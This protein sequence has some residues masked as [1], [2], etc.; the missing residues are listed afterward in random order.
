MS[1]SESCGAAAATCSKLS[2]S[3]SRSLSERGFQE[4][5]QR[6]SSGV[7]ES[8]RLGDGGNDQVGIAD[9]SQR[10]E[11]HP[12]GK[13]SQQVRGDLQ[14]QACFADAAGASEGQ[15]AHLWSAQQT[16]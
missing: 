5:Q 9:G 15:Q 2:S 14:R 3:N 4:V 16:T 10:D 7:L 6:L 1:S 12:V 8:E 11:A 13:V